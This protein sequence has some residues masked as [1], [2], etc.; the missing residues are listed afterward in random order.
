MAICWKCISNKKILSSNLKLHNFQSPSML[1]IKL[2]HTVVKINIL[3]YWGEKSFCL[4][5][6]SANEPN[7]V[8]QPSSMTLSECTLLFSKKSSAL[9]SFSS[10]NY[11]LN[12]CIYIEEVSFK[13]QIIKIFIQVN[14]LTDSNENYL[15][16]YKC[17]CTNQNLKFS[18]CLLDW[19][20]FLANLNLLLPLLL[21]FFWGGIF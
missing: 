20:M 15:V 8:D 5:T 9:C 4:F 3:I 14:R 12:H 11:F 13:D 17:W 18:V 10:L 19:F 7:S 1:V 16:Q 2:C 21:F 6:L